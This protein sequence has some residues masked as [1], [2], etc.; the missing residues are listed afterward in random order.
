MDLLKPAQLEPVAKEDGVVWI[1]ELPENVVQ[2]RR[3]ATEVNQ[4]V[5][6]SVSLAIAQGLAVGKSLVQPLRTARLPE[7]RPKAAVIGTDKVKLAWYPAIGAFPRASNGWPEG[8]V[9]GWNVGSRG[10]CRGSALHV[11]RPVHGLRNLLDVLSNNC[12]VKLPKGEHYK[13][14]LELCNGCGKCVEACP[15]GY[16]EVN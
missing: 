5:N 2:D 15:C 7:D 14:R 9:R 16:V 6:N 13:I 1:G 12:F 11:V 3:E 10:H 8:G 4:R